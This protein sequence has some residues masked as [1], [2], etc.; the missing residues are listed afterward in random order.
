MRAYSTSTDRVGYRD[1]ANK[2]VEEKD[3]IKDYLFLGPAPR[4]PPDDIGGV[5]WYLDCYGAHGGLEGDLRRAAVGAAPHPGHGEVGGCGGGRRRGERE[6]RSEEGRARR[7][8][9]V[10][11]AWRYFVYIAETTIKLCHISI[12]WKPED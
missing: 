10:Q 9:R 4:E 3:E 6:G 8:R 2:E 5:G 12:F 11:G 7:G 1:S